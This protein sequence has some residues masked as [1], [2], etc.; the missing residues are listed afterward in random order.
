VIVHPK[1]LTNDALAAA[2]AP[3]LVYF[4]LPKLI[5]IVGV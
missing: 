3:P 2:A 5:L 1:L 4:E